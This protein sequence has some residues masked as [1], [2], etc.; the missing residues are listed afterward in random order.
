VV[1]EVA[2]QPSRDQVTEAPAQPEPTS[3]DESPSPESPGLET[4]AGAPSSTAEELVEP[5]EPEHA[6]PARKVTLAL[7]VAIVVLVGV[8][9][10]QAAYLWGPLVDDPTV[11]ADRPVLISTPAHRSAVDTAKVA[12]EKLTA[13]S[14]QNYDEQVD[15]AAAMMTTSFAETYRETT[16]QVKEEFIAAETEVTVSVEAQSVMTASDN[17]V[18]ALIFL[19][20]FTAKKGEE[21]AF[22]PYRIKV[23]MIDTEQGW[24]VSDVETA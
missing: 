20:Q 5:V 21:T 7:V 1:E 13:R 4:G 12:V 22:T 24:L 15:E 8:A 2:L 11:T 17:Q 19:T 6:P 9:A 23:T 14:Y 16:D 3:V 10:L 18:E